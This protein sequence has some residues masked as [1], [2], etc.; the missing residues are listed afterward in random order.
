MEV[1]VASFRGRCGRWTFLCALRI[2]AV[3]KYQRVGGRFASPGIVQF[4]M[5]RIYDRVR[6]RVFDGVHNMAWRNFTCG[7]WGGLANESCLAG[8]TH[9]RTRRVTPWI[10]YDP[11]VRS[12]ILH[13]FASSALRT[14]ASLLFGVCLPDCRCY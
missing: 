5:A 13:F 11:D 4:D 8:R 2:E 7:D 6:R 10:A 14:S 1:D 9:A 3:L 12:Y